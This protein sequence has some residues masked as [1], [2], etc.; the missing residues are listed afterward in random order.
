MAVL[1]VSRAQMSP[2]ALLRGGASAYSSAA[3]TLSVMQARTLPPQ[4]RHY[5]REVVAVAAI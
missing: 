4:L 3:M 5:H 1:E 2:L